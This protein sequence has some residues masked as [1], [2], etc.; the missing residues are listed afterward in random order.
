MGNEVPNLNVFYTEVFIVRWDQSKC[1]AKTEGDS[2]PSTVVFDIDAPDNKP[3]FT[4]YSRH[5]IKTTKIP[6]ISKG[7]DSQLDIVERVRKSKNGEIE[8]KICCDQGEG[9]DIRKGFC[10][11]GFVEDVTMRSCDEDD[12]DEEILHFKEIFDAQLQWTSILASADATKEKAI[13]I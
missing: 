8:A 5:H 13:N 6:E 9:K 4:F 11:E 1:A 3:A 2:F 10:L 12:L 7:V